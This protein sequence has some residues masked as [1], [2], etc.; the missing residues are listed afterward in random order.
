MKKI[1]IKPSVSVYSVDFEP[2]LIS[3]SGGIGKDEGP[4]GGG[5]DPEG[6]EDETIWPTSL[7]D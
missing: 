3:G 2:F 4:D 1:Y 7:W 5:G 6:P